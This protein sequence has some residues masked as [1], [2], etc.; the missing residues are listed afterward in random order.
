V[1]FFITKIQRSYY[2]VIYVV[3]VSLTVAYTV[4]SGWGRE[5]AGSIL[6]NDC[7]NC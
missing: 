3:T 1:L 2:S 5:R 6:F 4:V 7:V